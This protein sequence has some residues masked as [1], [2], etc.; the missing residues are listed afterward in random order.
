MKRALI[1]LSVLGVTAGVAAAQSKLLVL[2][3]DG[4]ADAKTRQKVDAALVKLA[5]QGPDTVTPGEITFPEAADMVGCKSDDAG[6][7]DQVIDALGVDELVIVT[8]NPK[9]PGFEISVRRAKKGGAVHEAMAVVAADKVDQVATLGPLFG[10]KS[11]VDPKPIDPKP[12]DPKPPIGP[13]PFDPKPVDPKP[14][15]PKPIDIKPINPKP[16]DPKPP[17]DPIVDPLKPKPVEVAPAKPP[18][19]RQRLYIAG[20][21]GGGGMAFLSFIM[22]SAASGVQSQIDDAPTRT[23]ADLLR[24]QDLETKGDRLA[25]FGNVFFITG[26]VLGGVS[27]YFYVKN[28]R[29]RSSEKRE[30]PSPTASLAPALFDHGAGISLTI[31]GS[32]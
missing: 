13:Q 27:T 16:V 7:R 20:M 30:K 18:K 1:V 17:T 31:G 12:V 23:R 11:S 6:C 9:P 4:K 10:L 8:V 29:A 28:R 22:W 5:K 25:G 15:D 24:L 19:D 2:H 3:S 21:A 26:I 14:M 32:P